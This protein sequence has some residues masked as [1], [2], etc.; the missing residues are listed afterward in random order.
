MLLAALT[1]LTGCGM[2]G[3]PQP[4]S[5]NLPGLVS[6]LSAV[7]TSDQVALTWKMPLRN[8]DKILLKGPIA[9][10]ICRDQYSAARCNAVATLEL[11]P[12]ADATFTDT[13]PPGLTSGLPQPLSYFVEL[14][15]RK[16][17]SAGLSNAA[18]VLAG[19]APDAVGG[20][21]AEVRKGGVLLRWSPASPDSQPTAIRFVRTLLTPPVKESRQ[22]PLAAPPEPLQRN[23]FVDSA[24]SG[25]AIDSDIHF[26]ESYEYRA[27]RVS[28]VTQNGQALELA[29]PL[30]AA[31][32]VDAQDIF[33]PNVPQGLAAVATAGENGNPPA[34]DLSWQP[35]ADPN[36]AGYIVYRKESGTVAGGSSSVGSE[37]TGEWQRISP[38]QPGIEPDFRDSNV[39]TGHS[40]LYAVSAI[41]K[42]GHESARSTPAGDT[43]PGP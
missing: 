32:R 37:N 30:S 22:G 1:A 24:V 34:I 36:L 35:D 39:Q 4:P 33:P 31:V 27:Q 3:A 10:R 26:G 15:N 38:A 21:S 42:N 17:R 8:T 13:L 25:R 6:N 9:T 11:N 19:Q 18:E 7:R 5:L 23:L 28:R 41:A 43:V 12:G 20:F 29:G 14:V 40:Y 2:P 16:G